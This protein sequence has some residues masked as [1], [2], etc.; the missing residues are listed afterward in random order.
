MAKG[1]IPAVAGMTGMTINAVK[2]NAMTT[3]ILPRV[4]VCLGDFLALCKPRVVALITLTAAAGAGL[5]ATKHQVQPV[6]VVAALFGITLVAAAAAAFNC[7]VEVWIDAKMKRTR[8]RP[9]PGGRLSRTQAAVFATLLGAAGLWITAHFGGVLA[10]L[11]TAAALFGY[12]VVYT[13]F[14]K[15]TTPQN[16]VIGGASGA[17]PPV[18]GWAA[19][20]DGISYEPLLLF[21]IIFVW[22]PPHFWALALYRQEDYARANLPMLPNTHGAEFTAQ[23]IVLYA[24]AL[25]AVS[26]LPFAAAV[27]VETDIAFGGK[28]VRPDLLITNKTETFVIDYKSGAADPA[29]HRAQLQ[30]YRQAAAALYPQTK[31][32]TAILAPNG[33]LLSAD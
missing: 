23:M 17:M 29:R 7:L 25:L 12:A 22:T 30:T 19:A 28:V 8:N 21:L 13:L 3:S 10:A 14:L 4:R 9:L 5:A 32:H 33:K 6:A 1:W 26:L 27:F 11:L 31:V 16:I 2:I 18:L 24:A 15:N 20:A